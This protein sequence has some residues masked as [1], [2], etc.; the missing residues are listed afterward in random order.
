MSSIGT[1]WLMSFW[2]WQLRKRAEEMLEVGDKESFYT[3]LLS[4][5]SATCAP[6]QL[7]FND[8]ILVTAVNNLIWQMIW[9]IRPFGLMSN[10]GSRQTYVSCEWPCIYHRRGPVWWQERN[11]LS[12]EKQTLYSFT[13]PFQ[14]L[15]YADM[16]SLLFLSCL[17]SQIQ[18][19]SDNNWEYQ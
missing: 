14:I 19:E 8:L 1:Y 15:L 17:K 9:S 18:E 13:F 16:N 4:K 3:H 11:T 6:L 12:N 10:R 5:A 2:C 7:T